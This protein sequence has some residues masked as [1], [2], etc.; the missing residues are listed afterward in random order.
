MMS[1]H[2]TPRFA[3]LGTLSSAM[4]MYA[5]NA[6]MSVPP[7]S[8]SRP[9]VRFTPLLAPMIA[10]AAKTTNTMGTTGIGPTK[11]TLMAVMA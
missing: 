2:S 5:T 4:I 9:S 10:P 6:K 11:G 1:A 8:P 7:A 3:W